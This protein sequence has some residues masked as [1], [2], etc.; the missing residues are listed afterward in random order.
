MIDIHTHVLPRVDDG[1][2]GLDQA[3][4]MCRAAAAAGTE[5]LVATP[6]LLHPQWDGVTRELAARSLEA[7]EARLEGGIELRL[8]AEI[9]MGSDLLELADLL[10]GGPLV[11]LAGSRYLLL[12]MPFVP[13]LPDVR[14]IVH[15]LVLAGWKPVLSHPERMPYWIG[16][17]AELTELVGLGALLQVTAM[18]LTGGFGRK[19]LNLG[20]RL[21]D[22]GL[23]HFVASDGH[24]PEY[25][26]AVMNE[27]HAVVR[28]TWGER[29]AQALF[30][31]NPRAVIED[32]ELASGAGDGSPELR[33]MDGER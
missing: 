15:E 33:A 3:L 27:A 24:D 17:P 30:V 6:H 5:V 23:V 20:R 21:V 16:A 14:M 31:D 4:A 10:P 2:L 28:R 1:A 11:L 7:L 18:S 13:P 32:R 12:E 26:P 9:H 22:G 25:R 19:V 8:G 29:A